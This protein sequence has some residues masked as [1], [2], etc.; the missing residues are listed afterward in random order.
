MHIKDQNKKIVDQNKEI[1]DQNI[2]IKLQKIRI[3]QLSKQMVDHNEQI[4]SLQKC[5]TPFQWKFKLDE[6]KGWERREYSPP[7]YD[8]MNSHCF[9]LGACCLNNNLR[10]TVYKYRGKY[11]ADKGDDIETIN[12]FSFRINVFGKVGKQNQQLFINFKDR[13]V[14]KH[15]IRSKGWYSEINNDDINDLTIDGYLNLHCFFKS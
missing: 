10:I 11:D 5:Q 15:K 2:Q 12:T 3:E 1:E 9:Q 13:S 4:T 7:F 6:I 8:I 14:L